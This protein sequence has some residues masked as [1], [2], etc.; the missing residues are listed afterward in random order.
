MTNSLNIEKLNQRA[1][2]LGL[3]QSGIARKLEV[4]REAVSQWFKNEKFPRP[5]K[6]LKLARLLDLSFSDLVNRVP[7]VNEPV[8]AFRKKAGRKISPDY[9]DQAR[10]MGRIL[11]TL[12]PQLPF[13]DL[14]LPP[15]LKFPSTDYA[16]VQKAAKRV[17]VEIGVPEGEE[18]PFQK[19]IRYF[20]DLHAVIIPVLWGNKENHEN[21][22]HIYLPETMSTWIYLNLDCQM[23]D[24]KYWMSHELGHVYA[25]QLKS[26]D[27]EDFAEAFAAALLVPEELASC[28]YD[29][30]S[31]FTNIGAQINHIKKVAEQL[32][33]SP[34]TVYY[35]INKYATHHGKTRIDLE[36]GKEIHKATSNF[37]KQ[38]KPVSEC[39]FGTKNPSPTRYMAS[40]KEHF[41]SPF[42]DI[43]KVYIANNHKSASFIQSILNIPLLDAQNVY[44]ELC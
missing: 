43:L 34:L 25:P 6:L 29:A 39:L 20:N 19:L 28:E 8:V 26:D 17:R 22:L 42:F 35:E 14:S 44:E 32:V 24:F 40:A 1:E 38:F 15:Y 12:A 16:Y 27:G 41:G 31:R 18:V 10:D 2:E 23:H 36:S 4:T 37:N 30:L 7:T 5:D 13:D 11:A 3:N 33:V 21:A 9:L